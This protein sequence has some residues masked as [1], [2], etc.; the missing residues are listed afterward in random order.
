MSERQ[1]PSV[2]RSLIIALAQRYTKILIM[3][4]TVM[5]ISRLLTPAQIGVYSV[6]VAFVSLAHMLRDLGV[7]EYLVQESNLNEL[8]SRSAFTVTLAFAW[9][10]AL[11]IF[12]G[13]PWISS[14]YHEEG[15]ESVLRILSINFLIIP[16]GSTVI[17]LLQREMRFGILYKINIGQQLMQSGVSISLAALG[18]GYIGLAWASVCGMIATTVGCLV[19]G[20]AYRI[21]G[22]SLA[23]WRSVMRFGVVRATGDIIT[24]LG[25][26]APD[27]VVGRMLGFTDV[28]LY[29]RGYGLINLYRQNIVSAFNAVTFP[30]FARDHR[31]NANAHETFLKSLTVLTGISWPFLA[32]AGLMAFPVMRAVFGPQWDA[33]IPILQISCAAAFIGTLVFQCGYYLTAIG[34]V[35]SVTRLESV[36]QIIWIAMLIPAAMYNLKAVAGTQVIFYLLSVGGY[37]SA[38]FKW[39]KISLQD[40][41]AA[42]RASFL[43]AVVSA[44][45]PICV[46]W[47]MPPSSHNLWSDLAVSGAGAVAGWIATIYAT[48]HP[49][50]LEVAKATTSI[51]R[52]VG[53]PFR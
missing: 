38:L 51:R 24:R 26:S 31:N 34:R 22:L 20:R 50:W 18:F 48:H 49:L 27:F 7:S 36:L 4:P 52:W 9:F 35:G 28:G 29:S 15:L 6:A 40:V 41:L 25:A 23:H 45:A 3:F 53:R 37:Y 14:F 43:A 5:T 8:K 30:A 19:W 2:R 10:L 11:I 17:S 16:F 39:S 12:L 21:K 1:T 42:C 13:A 47:F 33:A 32:F 46:C 44:V